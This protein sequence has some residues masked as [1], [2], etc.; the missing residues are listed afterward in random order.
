[1]LTFVFRRLLMVLPVLAGLSFILFAYV[2]LLPG[3][4]C[5]TILGVHATP[6]L[7]GRIRE[8]L[9][10]NDPIWQQYLTYIGGLLHGDFGASFITNKSVIGEFAT[11]FPA[12]LELTAA[13]LIFAVGAGIP[14]GRFAARHAHGWLDGSVSIISLLGISIPVFVLGLALVFIFSVEL[15]W[16]PTQGRIDPR[17]E[18]VF[19]TI[20][21][22]VLVDT[23][24]A[25]R[26]DLFMDGLRHL[27]LPAIAQGSIPLAIIA[28]QT[29]AAVLDVANE[30][31]VRTAE[32]K[33]LQPR[34]VEGRHIMR[35]AWLPVMT[36]IGLQVGSLLGGAVL[37][38]T[39]FS[40]NGVGRWVFEAIHD[41]DYLVVQGGI[42]VFA[43][44][45]L[46]VNLVVDVG[47][48]FLNPR[49]RYS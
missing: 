38:E 35:N 29:R 42:T 46:I 32:A 48:A 12:T 1:M 17:A 10:L 21:G 22:F 5:A 27:I 15:R 18:G 30:D 40:W 44:I 37:T 47:Y 34:R 28:R 20:T 45:F 41:R 24:L 14:L 26:L 2:H 25:G 31:Y 11:R 36:I 7:C 4:P 3:D 19:P 43:L 39:I 16:L 49:I 33:G 23:L 13:A 6:E 8:S 9:G